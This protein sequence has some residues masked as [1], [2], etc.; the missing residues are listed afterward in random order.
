MTS[1]YR[2]IQSA[3]GDIRILIVQPGQ[4]QDPLTCHLEVARLSLDQGSKPENPPSYEAISYCWGDPTPCKPC[5]LDGISV[6]IPVSASEVIHRFRLPDAP[7]RIWIDALCINQQDITER[8]EQV[9]LMG[10]VYSQCTR[11]LIW[12]GPDTDNTAKTAFDTVDKVC[13]A[14][15]EADRESKDPMVEM[16]SMLSSTSFTRS[17]FN[18]SFEQR[19]K[20]ERGEPVFNLE[21]T[22]QDLFRLLRRPWFQRK[23]VFQEAVLAPE[24]TVFCGT[25]TRPL[26]SI[27]EAGHSLYRHLAWSHTREEFLMIRDLHLLWSY[28]SPETNDELPVDS[29]TLVALLAFL[30]TKFSTDPKDAVFSVLGL[31]KR[32]EKTND[33]FQGLF[34]ADYRRSL[35]DILASATKYAII[36][37]QTLDVLR[38]VR[39]RL[40]EDVET[41]QIP[42]WVPRWH[43]RHEDIDMGVNRMSP[44]G[45]FDSNTKLELIDPLDVT[46]LKC[47]GE[48]IDDICY[49]FDAPSKDVVKDA[50]ALATFFKSMRSLLR[51]DILSQVFES[52][53]ID[54]TQARRIRNAILPNQMYS[55]DEESAVISSTLMMGR[56]YPMQEYRGE[57]TSDFVLLEKYLDEP[58]LVLPTLPDD[59]VIPTSTF[60]DRSPGEQ[61]FVRFA[62]VMRLALHHR[63]FFTTSRGLI[64]IGPT[65]MEVCDVVVMLH[66]FSSPVV[67]RPKGDGYEFLES[68]YVHGLM[69]GRDEWPAGVVAKEEI[70]S[71]L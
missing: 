27:L 21:D 14:A 9:S 71:I 69:G 62:M 44:N 7:R 34:K 41:S 45:E 18:A 56:Q 61:A 63:A 52:T 55:A 28:F 25:E 57:E 15:R 47:R 36:E 4:L 40:N 67:L 11:C 66:G 42:S 43:L 65:T 13:H 33:S 6:K 12:L 30:R 23:W 46:F 68:C 19:L 54:D 49:R 5:D 51:R 3:A 22:Q 58:G 35:S 17:V 37:T 48:M 24:S 20:G 29:R 26:S 39:P 31:V 16:L 32:N 70:I 2:R 38:F 53:A 59:E 1:P 60:K 8:G 64:G 50:S 10:A